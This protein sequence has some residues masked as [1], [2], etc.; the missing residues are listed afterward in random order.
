LLVCGR[1]P[2][3]YKDAEQLSDPIL[4]KAHVF[5]TPGFI[6]GEN[7]AQY[8]RISACADQKIVEEAKDSIMK[9]MK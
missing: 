3:C 5:I 2:S 6:F 1:I 7:G 8:L 4:N 9:I